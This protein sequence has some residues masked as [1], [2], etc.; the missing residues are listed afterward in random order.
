M[1]RLYGLEDSEQY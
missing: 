1:L